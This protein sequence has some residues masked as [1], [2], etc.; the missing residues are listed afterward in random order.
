MTFC[1]DKVLGIFDT[2]DIFK[3]ECQREVRTIFSVVFNGPMGRL[4]GF[5]SEL[6]WQIPQLRYRGNGIITVFSSCHWHRLQ[7]DNEVK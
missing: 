7:F 3:L 2:W 5:R 1:A 4:E 6:Y